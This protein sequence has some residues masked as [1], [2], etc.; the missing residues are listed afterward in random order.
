[1]KRLLFDPVVEHMLRCRDCD[2]VWPC[3]VA[4]ALMDDAREAAA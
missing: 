1:V 3:D 2:T 4:V